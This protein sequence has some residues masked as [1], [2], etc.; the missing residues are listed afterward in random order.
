MSHRQF[1]VDV[2]ARVDISEVS[3]FRVEGSGFLGS[4]QPS[5]KKMAGQIEKE[6]N[7]H[8][9]SN[10]ERPTSNNVSCQYNLMTERSDSALDV[11]RWKFDV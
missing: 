2:T 6:T 1:I 5:A 10:T 9:T 11:R 3:G 4:A 7:E 8:R